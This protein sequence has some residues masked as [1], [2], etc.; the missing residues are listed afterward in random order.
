M[1]E[2]TANL[3]DLLLDLARALRVVAAQAEQ[4]AVAMSPRRDTVG[5][6]DG[7]SP[8]QID[9]SSLTVQWN[10]HSCFL[11]YTNAFRLIERLARRPNH[12]VSHA[13]L[14]ADVWGGPRSRS[15]IW[16]AIADLKIRLAGAGLAELASAID[17]S[18]PGH[19][20]LIIQRPA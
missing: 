10:G 15:A 20:G 5:A 14:L 7:Q 8:L 18:N 3:T 4:V 11:G 9:R 2:H 1:H 12:Y 19:Y 13:Q 16:S 6:P 17:G